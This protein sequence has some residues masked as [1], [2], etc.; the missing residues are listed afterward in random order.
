MQQDRW[1]RPS[2]SHLGFPHGKTELLAGC[3]CVDSSVEKGELRRAMSMHAMES[4]PID[5]GRVWKESFLGRSGLRL[6]LTWVGYLCC[7]HVVSPLGKMV[8][9]LLFLLLFCSLRPLKFGDKVCLCFRVLTVAEALRGCETRNNH[10]GEL[11][12]F[13]Q[14][15]IWSHKTKG[16]LTSSTFV[17]VLAHA[18]ISVVSDR[19]CCKASANTASYVSYT[20][21]HTSVLLTADVEMFFQT[22]HS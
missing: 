7:S 9:L 22:R 6:F 5:L 17:W 4:C 19:S 3:T 21:A 20:Q 8:V 1:Q 10:K 16:I 12:S 13:T 14:I 2:R 18:P 15:G 11:L